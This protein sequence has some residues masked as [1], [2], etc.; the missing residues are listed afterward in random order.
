VLTYTCAVDIAAAA[1]A[2]AAAAAAAAWGYR[3][4]QAAVDGWYNEVQQYNF[5]AP[6][7]S[8]ATGGHTSQRLQQLYMHAEA[9]FR[10]HG[11]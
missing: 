7:F 10:L 2:A 9:A 3:S 8:G 11:S 4:W 6:G 1:G 5:A